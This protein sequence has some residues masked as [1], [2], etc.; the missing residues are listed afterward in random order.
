MTAPLYRRLLGDRF[1]LLPAQVRGLHDLDRQSVWVGRA[2]VERG[3]SLVCRMIAA[4]TR[5]PPSGAEQPLTVTFT[6]VDGAELWH[7]AFGRRVLA[8][9]QV[10][11]DGV[12]LERIGPATVALAAD[13]T[14]AGLTLSVA[15]LWVLGVPMPS[16]LVPE[17]ATREYETEG[18]YRFEVEARMRV[19]GRLV[20]YAGWLEPQRPDLTVTSSTRP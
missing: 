16:W 15:H 11:G 4:V 13:V 3:T 17:V 1:A 18:R 6:A 20:R 2:D 19:F 9:R 12:I 8:S 14:P 5:L 10:L 7:R